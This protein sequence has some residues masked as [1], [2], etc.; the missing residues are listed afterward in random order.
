MVPSETAHNYHH[1]YCTICRQH[2]TPT[3]NVIVTLS[4]CNSFLRH[5]RWSLQQPL[6]FGN[7][8]A[9]SRSS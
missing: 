5:Y 7:H 6:Q 2:N 3:T 8:A 9:E 4:N 1:T